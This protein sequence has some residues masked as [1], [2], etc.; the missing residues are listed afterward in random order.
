MIAVPVDP[1]A[2]RIFDLAA[3]VAAFGAG[4]LVSRWRLQDARRSFPQRPGYLIALATGAV[5]GAY[6]AGTLPSL[7]NG[8]ASLS[9]SVAGALAGA[10]VGV[11]IYKAANGITQSTGAIFV[12]PFAVGIVIG[13]WGCL[14]AGLA[15]G[16]YGTPTTLPFGVDLGD[17]VARHPVQVYESLAMLAFLVAYVAALRVRA[18]WA[19][20]HGF[21]AMAIFYGAQRFVWEFLKPYPTLIG[22]FNLFHF[23]ALGLLGYGCVFIARARSR[24][25]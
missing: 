19:L 17:G 6:I 12:A 21:Y 14:Y 9:H 8:T 18:K 15:D 5:L 10:I 3:W 11:E 20:A 25:A 13:R 23:I 16:T 2:H 1:E 4:W 22:P 24:S 7:M